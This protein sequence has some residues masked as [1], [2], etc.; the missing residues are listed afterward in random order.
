M[1]GQREIEIKEFPMHQM[2]KN[3]KAVIIGKPATGKSTLIRDIVNVY[4]HQIPTATVFSGSEENNQFYAEMFP[5]L[6]VFPEYSEAEMTNIE[7]RQKLAMRDPS[8]T[9]ARS[10]LILDDVSDDK[11]FFNRP[12]YQR[13]IKNGRHWELSQLQALQYGMDIPKVIRSSIDYTFIFRDPIESNRKSI[14]ENYAS[15]IGNSLGRKAGYD[16][17][18][19]IMDQVTGDYT[20]L[21]INNR[22]ET[23]NIEDCIG[24]YKARL[25]DSVEFGCQ[26]YRQWAGARY[27]KDYV[28]DF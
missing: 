28:M 19:D 17:F 6:Y 7:K 26:E 27:N 1:T 15:I 5:D 16:Y 11:K 10:L 25:W 13:F 22:V 24:W 3:F 4:K 12:L 2:K 18:C 9:N 23:N 8:L 14:Y 20:A 21:V